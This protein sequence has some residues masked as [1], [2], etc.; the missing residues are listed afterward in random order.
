MKKLIGLLCLTAILIATVSFETEL[1][2]DA[3]PEITSIKPGFKAL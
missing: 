1:A 3:K 2:V